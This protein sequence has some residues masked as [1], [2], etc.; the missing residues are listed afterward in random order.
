LLTCANPIAELVAEGYGEWTV[1]PDNPAEVNIEDATSNDTSVSGFAV[2]GEYVFY[3][4]TRYCQDSVTIVY[5][6]IEELPD[7]ESPVEYCLGDVAEPLVAEELEGYTLVFYTE[8]FGSESQT[9]IIPDTSE[10]GATTY[11]AAYQDTDG[12]EGGRVPIDVIVNDLT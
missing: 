5:E 9:Q 6:G 4:N 7:V 2:P 11:Y 3:W 8:E 12:C 1:D 10:P